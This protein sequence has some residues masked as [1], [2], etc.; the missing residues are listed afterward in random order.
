MISSVRGAT[1]DPVKEIVV[2]QHPTRDGPSFARTLHGILAPSEGIRFSAHAAQRLSQRAIQLTPTQQERLD[3]ALNQAS[4]SGARESL[5][6]M[7]GVAFVVN[8]PNRTVITAMPVDDMND[9]V[10][11]NIDS[12]VVAP[13]GAGSRSEANDGPAPLWEAPAPRTA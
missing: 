1:L 10:I 5:L 3:E 6:L 7:D 13:S 4:A 12:A 8:V 11:T 2:S 9:R